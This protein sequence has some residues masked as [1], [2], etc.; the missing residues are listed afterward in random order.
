MPTP[1][2]GFAWKKG[3]LVSATYRISMHK[4][5]AS[6][7]MYEKSMSE[8]FKFIKFSEYDREYFNNLFSTYLNQNPGNLDGTNDDRELLFKQHIALE[9]FYYVG[10]SSYFNEVEK[11]LDSDQAHHQISAI[12]ALSKIDTRA[13]KQRILS[14]IKEES[15]NGLARVLAVQ[16]LRRLD[17]RELTEDIE[18]YLPD[19]STEWVGFGLDILDPRVGTRI[20]ADLKSGI[21]ELLEDWK[22]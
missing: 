10:D 17:A 21:E 20:P 5:F 14:F 8:I 2:S 22:K 4:A 9:T 1:T 7:D 6:V 16:A 13:S 3:N 19:A 12:R 15:N 18:E 11:F